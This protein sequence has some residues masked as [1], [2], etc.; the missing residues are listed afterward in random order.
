MD[1]D[2]NARLELVKALRDLGATEVEVDGLRA[3]FPGPAPA[4][5]PSLKPLT[6]LQ[7]K[8]AVDW[9]DVLFHSAGGV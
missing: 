3:V 6:E 2:Y 8:E 4:A 9:E 1:P 7:P 5:P